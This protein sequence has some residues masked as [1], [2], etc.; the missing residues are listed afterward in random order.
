MNVARLVKPQKPITVGTYYCYYRLNQAD[1]VQFVETAAWNDGA[2]VETFLN[3]IGVTNATECVSIE[4]SEK[5]AKDSYRPILSYDAKTASL[6]DKTLTKKM[7]R[8]DRRK[9]NKVP[10]KDDPWFANKFLIPNIGEILVF[11]KIV[12]TKDTKPTREFA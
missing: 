1:R 6:V 5:V 2:A 8:K 12:V 10:K 9:L 3:R 7:S 11:K 4:V